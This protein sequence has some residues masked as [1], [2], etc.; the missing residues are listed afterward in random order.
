MP[1]ARSAIRSTLWISLAAAILLAS[2]GVYW[3]TQGRPALSFHSRDSVLIADFENQTGDPRF[4][5][6]LGTAFDVSME[7]SR[8]ANVFPRMQFDAILK[9]MG[10]PQSERITPSLGR[11]ICQRESVRGL[12]VSSITR[13]GQEYALTAQ[14]IDPQSGE[15][16]R[17]YT[18]RSYGEDHILDALDVLSRE[19]REALGES[20]YQIHQAG[21]PLPQV[22]TRSLNALQQ[23]A[24]GSALWPR[25][26]TSGC[27]YFVQSCGRRRSRLYYGPCGSRQR[28]LQLYLQPAG[29]WAKGIRKGPLLVVAHHRPRTNDHRST[30]CIDPESRERVRSAL[31]CLFEPLPGR[32]CNAIRLRHLV[33]QEWPPNRRY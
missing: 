25:G 13:T 23:Y 33:A 18:E 28:V 2:G 21:K 8:Y 4:D 1:G 10:R 32:C 7:Q 5:T 16:V 14:L 11:E 3:L 12:I 20:L 15:T 19:I 24:E 9:R 29:R 22:T 31:Q 6:A 30:I 26:K 17:S 27:G